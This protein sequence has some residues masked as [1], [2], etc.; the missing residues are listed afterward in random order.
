MLFVS[1]KKVISLGRL[2]IKKNE[3][4]FIEQIAKEDGI[5]EENV[6]LHVPV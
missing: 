3:F 4:S 6:T 1:S 2:N 5:L